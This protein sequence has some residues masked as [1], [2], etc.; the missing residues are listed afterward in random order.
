[1]FLDTWITTDLKSLGG[2]A[3]S[4]AIVYLGIIL[5][6]RFAGLRSFSKMSSSDFAMTVAVGSLFA[7]TIS[8]PDPTLFLGLFALGGLFLTQWLISRLRKRT[9]F[10]SHLIDNKP[11]LLMRGS[12]MLEENMKRASV[13]RGDML[14]KLREA[15]VLNFDQVQAVV[16]EATG[17]ISVLHTEG[18]DEVELSD[19]I[20]EGVIGWEKGD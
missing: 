12:E 1:M 6:C 3:V 2:V 16:F 11:L 14:G 8:S 17:D 10:A 18:D 4:V 15:N 7:A 20:L 13:T 9:R 19:S 5:Y